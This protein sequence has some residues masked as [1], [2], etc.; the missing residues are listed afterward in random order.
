MHNNEWIMNEFGDVPFGDERL[1]KR[2]LNIAELFYKNPENSIPQACQSYAATQ[3]TYR[4]FSNT[5][6]KSEALIMNHREQTIERI[7]QHNTVLII[8][9]TTSLNYASHPATKGLGSYSNT[10][11]DLGLLLH[12]S[13]SVSTIG[14]PLGILSSYTWTRDIEALGNLTHKH[15]RATSDKES[16]KWIDALNL[17]LKDIPNYVKAVTVCDREADFYDFFNEAISKTIHL[18]VRVA[19]KKRCLDDGSLLIESIEKSP[20][21]GNLIV[22]IP[23]DTKRR[24]SP[25]TANLSIR[26]G[27]VCISSP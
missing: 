10:K 19:Q 1:N 20:V 5:Q 12:T 15:K 26:Y 24:L 25:R 18:L 21:M 22:D 27:S 7:K 13:L 2:L 23:R 4:F 9:D 16:Q 17:S 14:I 6:V 11:H 3:A 8:Q